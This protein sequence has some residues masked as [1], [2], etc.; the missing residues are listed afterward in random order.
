MGQ[1]L[2]C[3]LECQG[4]SVL[5]SI[6][7]VSLKLKSNTSVAMKSAF[8]FQFDIALQFST[9]YLLPS[10][11]RAVSRCPGLLWPCVTLW[12]TLA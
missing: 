11:P 9:S 12:E 10:V 6:L 2:K 4:L 5:R 7:K 3:R 8:M 1:E